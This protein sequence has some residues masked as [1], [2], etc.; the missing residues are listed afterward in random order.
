MP[1]PHKLK[2]VVPLYENA[3]NWTFLIYARDWYS[4]DQKAPPRAEAMWS[5]WEVTAKGDEWWRPKTWYWAGSKHLRGPN[6]ESVTDFWPHLSENVMPNTIWVY[7]FNSWADVGGSDTW[8]KHLSDQGPVWWTYHC[9]ERKERIFWNM[10][11]WSGGQPMDWMK[12]HK[13]KSP[14]TK[15]LQEESTVGLILSLRGQAKAKAEA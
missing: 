6:E 1:G 12:M 9:S 4:L 7:T 15:S 11:W 8:V 3:D 14:K 2:Y 10:A 13:T 5:M